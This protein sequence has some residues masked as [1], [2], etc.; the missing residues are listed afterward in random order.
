MARSS[1]ARSAPTQFPPFISIAV[2]WNYG[3]NALTTCHRQ[4][5]TCRRAIVECA[6]R[7]RLS[8]VRLFGPLLYVVS[9]QQAERIRGSGDV[10]GWRVRRQGCHYYA[11][12]RERK[13]H[14]SRCQSRPA[15]AR[16]RATYADGAS[17]VKSSFQSP[18]GVEVTTRRHDQR[19]TIYVLN[20]TAGPQTLNGAGSGKDLL[21]NS[22]YSGEYSPRSVRCGCSSTGLSVRSIKQQI[23]P[24][25]SDAMK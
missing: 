19:T 14:L 21:T 3:L 8:A 1:R 13:V 11:H 20:H 4:A 22:N 23:V 6:M 2:L 17:G 7:C 9:R 16:T 15:S 5:K 25:I 24:R 12:L 10:H 18:H